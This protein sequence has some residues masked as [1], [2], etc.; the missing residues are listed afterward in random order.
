MAVNIGPRIGI[1]GEA[2]YRK[3]LQGI[4]TETK[5]L[6]TE[7]K[8][9]Q[10]SFDG[11]KRS[12][13]QNKAERELLTKQVEK[14]KEAVQRMSEM[15]EKAKKSTGEN[16][17]QTQKWH[18]ALNKA[19][20][21]LNNLQHRLDGMPN[22]IQLV[23]DKMS[24]AAEIINGVGDK[25]KG[26][27]EGMSK[28]VTAPIVGVGTASIV[29][30]NE[31]DA[32][33]D[34]IIQ[35][36]GASG[37]TLASMQ[38][39]ME[40]VATS[41][42]TGFEDAGAAVGEV[43][44]RFGVM[45]EDLTELSGQF[46]KFAQLN[47]TD[48]SGSIDKVQSSMAAFGLQTKDAGS[49]LDT[50][51]KA[52]QD[53]GVS[54][55]A[56]AS[57][58]VS[59][60]TVLQEMGFDFNQSAGFVANLSKNGIDASAVMG[61]LKKALANATKEGKPL[62]QALEE[63]QENLVKA[64]NDTEAMQAATEL[65]GA[66]AGPQLAAAL[67]EGRIS[68]DESANSIEGWGNSVSDTFDATLDAPDQLNVTLNE[69]K[70]VGA[71]LGGTMLEMVVPALEKLSEIVHTAREA[72]AGLDDGQKQTII[73]IAGVAAAVGPV[74]MV[75]ST[76]V[77]VISSVVGAVGTITG[78]IG[79][80]A[81][82][83]TAAGGAAGILGAAIAAITSPI[84][85]A[86][87]A[88]GGI[89]A[90]GIVLYKN[91]DTIKQKAGE[92][93]E[94]VSTKWSEMTEAA[95]QKW[96]E[97]KQTTQQKWDEISQ[98]VS[99]AGNVMLADSSKALSDIQAAYVEHGGGISG[100]AAGIMTAVE[101]AFTTGY[102][103]LDSLTNGKFG[104]ICESFNEKTGGLFDKAQEVWENI[105]QTVQDGVDR[106][107]QIMDFKWELPKIKLPHFKITGEFSLRPPSTPHFEVDWY[108]KAMKNGVILN[109]PTIFGADGNT[110]LAGGEA[111]PEAV[112]GVES[113]MN[114]VRTA[115]QS[116]GTTVN[117]GGITINVMQR[118]G[119][120]S[121][122]FAHRVADIINADVQRGRAAW[123]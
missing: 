17:Q 46:I 91:W 100:A 96:E 52:G 87:A 104:E 105:K 77:G 21:E 115:V 111:G 99:E 88:I 51:N 123:A 114:M 64:E 2:E 45:G 37:E 75:L 25:I 6:D 7:M 8:K 57:T 10:S 85:I 14:Q 47:G 15:L 30:F 71:D 108:A 61:G 18:Q 74:L 109:R 41:I 31:V 38:K 44:T 56:L 32:G 1:D 81:A 119:E 120:D 67:R 23:G 95:S 66:K 59:N 3:Q 79:G 65:F 103:V 92:L 42:P 72:W 80:V 28:Y 83:F 50:L 116:A 112:V 33:L 49:V 26:V 36:T 89:I 19:E 53:S 90:V 98:K 13:K 101:G 68:L 4:I 106:L 9:L 54:M 16:S 82:A 76:V 93:A 40:D 63:L 69:L 107:K 86:I 122:A 24:A 22:A 78:A 97:I 60:S 117:N 11:D 29:A 43:N 121:E 73:T 12:L 58:L 102:D 48:V 39:S 110:L 27:G 55:D 94:T 5:T 118:D 62:D 84:G 34:T 113:L 35:K 70:I 20:T